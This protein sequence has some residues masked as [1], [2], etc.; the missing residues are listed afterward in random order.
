LPRSRFFKKKK[1]PKVPKPRGRR[2][3]FFFCGQRKNE[4]KGGNG[5][6]KEKKKIFGTA[7]NARKGG[8]SLKGKISKE[9]KDVYQPRFGKMA[10]VEM[11]MQVKKNENFEIGKKAGP[12]ETSQIR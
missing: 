12:R 5:A 7:K 4:K 3:F 8:F 6:A 9:E 10:P 2:F 11:E 1:G